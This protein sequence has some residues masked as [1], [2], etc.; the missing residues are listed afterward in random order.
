LHILTNTKTQAEKLK[1]SNKYEICQTLG[2]FK[3]SLQRPV[4]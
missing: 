3:S 4:A 2:P 1:L